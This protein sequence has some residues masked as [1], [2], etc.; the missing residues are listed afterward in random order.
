MRT[1]DAPVYGFIGNSGNGKFYSL[2]KVRLK[3]H[4][5]RCQNSSR[6]IR[7][8]NSFIGSLV[9]GVI[10]VGNLKCVDR[11]RPGKVHINGIS[12][13]THRSNRRQRIH[14]FCQKLWIICTQFNPDGIIGVVM[15]NLIHFQSRRSLFLNYQLISRI[16]CRNNFLGIFKQVSYEV[17]RKLSLLLHFYLKHTSLIRPGRYKHHS[18][19]RSADQRKNAYSADYLYKRNALVIQFLV[20]QS[21]NK[22]H[23]LLPHGPVTFSSNTFPVKS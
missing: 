13:A 15:S 7:R 10:G 8:K 23:K 20:P 12:V 14:T 11:I 1:R 5:R 9:S 18:Y 16:F 6:Y 2:F 19:D 17:G 4:F 22:C 21:L 3:Y